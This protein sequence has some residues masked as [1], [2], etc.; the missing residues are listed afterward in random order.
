MTGRL[1]QGFRQRFR[2]LLALV[3]PRRLEFGVELLMGRARER[4]RRDGRPLAFAL[5]ELY[6]FTRRRVVRRVEVTGACS[7]VQPPW[8]R[9]TEDRPPRFV[10]DS[11]LGGL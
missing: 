10:G 5:A 3:E 8:R 9:F 6:E 1:E 7:L 11:S 4:S 2:Q